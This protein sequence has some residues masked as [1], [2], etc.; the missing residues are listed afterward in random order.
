MLDTIAGTECVAVADA[1]SG[2]SSPSLLRSCDQQLAALILPDGNIKPYRP[3]PSDFRERFI[4]M[5]WD[6]IEDHYRTNWRIIRRWIEQ[7][8]GDQLRAERRLVSGGTARPNLRAESR[9]RRYVMGKTLG[10]T[11]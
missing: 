11:K 6:G 5:G 8:G 3:C 9:A 1:P 2:Q 4:E 7:S 10:K